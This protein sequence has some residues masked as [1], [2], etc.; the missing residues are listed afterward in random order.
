MLALQALSGA[1]EADNR[2]V[3]LL[4]GVGRETAR[5]ALLRLADEGWIALDQPSEGCRAAHWRLINSRTS[6]DRSQAVPRP[7]GAGDAQRTTLLDT[8]TRRLRAACHD[9]FTHSPKGLGHHAGNTYARMTE[10][11][12]TTASLAN[13]TGCSP[14]ELAGTLDDLADV[15]V[16]TATGDHWQCSQPDQRD[17][18]AKRLGIQGRLADRAARY[19]VERELWAWWLAELAWMTAPGRHARRR[20]PRRTTVAQP[21]LA[22]GHVWDLHLPMPREH[23]THGRVAWADARAILAGQNPAPKTKAAADADAWERAVTLL[24]AVLGAELAA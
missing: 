12:Q 2:R 20:C 23:G 7:R 4:A 21:A 24:R 5:T 19:T 14:T 22:L 10:E 1:V 6:I 11:P 3:A 9:L 13:A 15:G 17:A 16:I 8:L 18:A